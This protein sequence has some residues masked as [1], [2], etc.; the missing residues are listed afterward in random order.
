MERETE[1]IDRERERER[2]E[3]A[4]VRRSVRT[5]SGELAVIGGRRGRKSS[6][7]E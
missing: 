7:L 5:G 4:C 2:V 3:E 6:G 1:W